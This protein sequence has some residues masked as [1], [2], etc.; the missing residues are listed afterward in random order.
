MKLRSLIIAS[1]LLLVTLAAPGTNAEI[2]RNRNGCEFWDDLYHEYVLNDFDT[3]TIDVIIVPSAGPYALRDVSTIER[4]IQM[5]EDGI[6]AGADD[7]M[8]DRFDV[9]TYTVG[10]DVIPEAALNDPEVIV[11][12]SEHN[13]FLLFG[14]GL[15][16]PISWC[17]GFDAYPSSS[18]H[19]HEGSVWAMASTECQG[20]GD[21]CVV[22]NTSFLLGGE[23]RM[24]DLNS[25][26]FGHCLG[27]GHVGDAM[28]F[29]AKTVPM[30]DIMSYQYTPSQVHCVS[31]LNIKALHGVYADA[32]GAPAGQPRYDG[33]EFVHMHPSD[34][35][36]FACSNPDA[37][38][39]VPLLS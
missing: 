20:G 14:I 15:A 9:R 7:W 22:L 10:F 18:W 27:I 37:A 3:G 2:C 33:G 24:F 5:W 23:R 16:V 4:S 17:H 19:Q 29:D 26:E 38:M 12:S 31:T 35:D 39:E 36:Q 21:Q 1:L 34:Y 6:R 32:L 11:L 28:D 25:H 8:A 30:Q 13:P